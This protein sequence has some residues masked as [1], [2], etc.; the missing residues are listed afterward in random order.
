MSNLESKQMRRRLNYCKKIKLVLGALI[1]AFIISLFSACFRPTKTNE[2]KVGVIAPLTGNVSKYGI[3]ALNGIE[4]YIEEINAEGGINGK[5]IKLVKYDDEGVALKSIDGYNFLID[6]KVVA[7]IN[8][9][10]SI[11]ALAISGR[12]FDDK[13][14]MVVAIATA[15]EI[16]YDSKN[17]ILFKN[18]FRM[19]ITD[20]SQGEKLGKFASNIIKAK[21]A[22]IIY[23]PENDYSR[24]LKESFELESKKRGIEI[25]GIESFSEQT[26]DFRSQ[27][28]RISNVKPDVIFVPHYYETVSLIL[29]QAEN[30]PI[31][32]SFLGADGWSSI[33]NLLNNLKLAKDLHYCTVF[34]KDEPRDIVEKFSANYENKFSVYPNTFAANG[35][36]SAKILVVSIQRALSKNIKQSDDLKEKIIK[37]LKNIELECVTGRITFD[38]FN[39]SIRDVCIIQIRKGKE[40][41][42]GKF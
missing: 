42:W 23:S 31:K 37:E 33:I 16:T 41:F 14:P 1:V 22:C 34:S 10:T 38:E 15:N 24:D 27:L 3:G 8:A 19:S 11:P 29:K 2:I 18:V 21:T 26:N 5:N 39:N 36:D 40:E 28:L 6:Q 30:F 4:L 35:Y 25:L 12:A 32:G 13:V 20:T 17:D 9:T 7:I